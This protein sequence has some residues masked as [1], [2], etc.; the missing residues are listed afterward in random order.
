MSDHAGDPAET[1]QS[2]V[3]F[4][5][6]K[7]PS[8]ALGVISCVLLF[9]M[10]MLTFIDVGGRYLFSSPLP[11]A[12]EIISLVMPGII[13]CA[14]P[15]V[16]HRETH[17]TIDLLDTF[18][19]PGIQRW[20]SIFVNLFS[21]SALGF[22]SWR[23]YARSIDHQRF[24]EVTDELFLKLWPFSLTMSILCAIATLALLANA[25]AY[26]TNTRSHGATPGETST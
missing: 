3:T 19:T 2:R 20:Q 23:L 15:F 18:L 6:G 8:Q 1:D 25:W 22:V 5:L 7:M 21:A 4:W 11:A 26:L 12:Y 24:Q 9:A 17:V 10:M 13:F 16:G 14:L